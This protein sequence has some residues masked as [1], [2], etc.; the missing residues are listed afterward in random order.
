MT[1]AAREKKAHIR[2]KRHARKNGKHKNDCRLGD[3]VGASIQDAQSYDTAANGR[4]HLQ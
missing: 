1:V 2:D 4:H 3:R